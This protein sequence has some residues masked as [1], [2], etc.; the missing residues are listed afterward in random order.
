MAD[1]ATPPF[2]AVGNVDGMEVP[3]AVAELCVHG[4]LGKAEQIFFMTS[5][6]KVVGPRRVGGV[7]GCRVG[8]F[9]QAEIVV[10]VGIV[11]CGALP[12]PDRAMDVF[13]SFQLSPNVFQRSQFL[14]PV[15]VQ[16]KLHF[17]KWQKFFLL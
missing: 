9:Q 10:A 5:E 16:T 11:A 1:P 6:A 12:G 7:Q 4:C 13:L 8:A 2:P 14:V 17:R 15:A 3:V